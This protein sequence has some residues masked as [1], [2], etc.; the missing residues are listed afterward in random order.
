[1]SV[2]GHYNLTS[3]DNASL[4]LH[5][6][7]AKP[8]G[9]AENVEQ[10]I[11]ITKGEGDFLLTDLHIVP[12]LPHVS[13]YAD[14]YPFASV[15]FGTKEE[16][17]E[18]SAADWIT[19]SSSVSTIEPQ[20][21]EPADLREAR[22]KLAELR[23]YLGEQNGDVQ[24]AMARV[25][26]LERMSKE[27]PN[28]PADEREAKAHLAELRIFHNEQNLDVQEA[29][30]KV[31]ALEEMNI[32]QS[33]TS[34]TL[35]SATNVPSIAQ[36]WLAL[37]DAGN[38]A[39]SWKESSQLARS[40]VTEDAWD[41]SLSGVREPLGTLVSRKLISAQSLTEMPGAPDGHY[42]VMQFDTSFANK[43]SAVET[44]TFML[45]KDGQWK[46]CGYFIK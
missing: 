46:S 40:L 39:E 17:D 12:G 24:A 29:L 5:V 4:E 27:E 36:V 28:A 38:Y 41:S 25:K 7:S 19:N 45:E 3:H 16:A 32:N 6:T 10:S 44:V 22:A 1:M 21:A 23:V 11:K 9:L 31:K 42:V 18:E 35:S 26:E 15:Y 34:E 13:M 43:K 14:G 37:I 30:A 33:T 2:M 20:E 8:A